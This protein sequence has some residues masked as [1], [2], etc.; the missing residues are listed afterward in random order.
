MYHLKVK[1]MNIMHSVQLSMQ[2]GQRNVKIYTESITTF[3]IIK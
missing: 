3:G 1:A 2:G